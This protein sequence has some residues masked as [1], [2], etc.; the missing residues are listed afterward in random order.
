M[1]PLRWG[2]LSAGKISHDFAVATAELPKDEHQV[3]AVGAR[4]L[5]RATEFAKIHKI[6]K[7]Y[8]SYEQLVKDSEIDVVYVGSIHPQ[9]LELVKLSLDHG[10]HVLCEKPL[11]MNVKETKEMLE[12]AQS[13]QLFLMEAIWSRFFPL[14]VELRKRLESNSLGDVLQVMVTFGLSL[15][16]R[17]LDMAWPWNKELGGGTTLGIGIYC[18]QFA[19]MVFGEKP[20]KVIAGGHLNAGGV[21]QS[22]T[23]TLIFSNGR[24]ATLVTHYKV[25]LPNEAYIFGTKGTLKVR[26]PFW[27]PTELEEVGGK[28]ISFPLPTEKLK[29][30]FANSVGLHYQCHEVRNCISNGKTESSIVSHHHTLLI[31]EIMESIRTQVGVVYP[32]DKH[33]VNQGHVVD[34]NTNWGGSSKSSR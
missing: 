17:G 30:N 19:E 14:Y 33:T 32:Q 21:D 22:T 23:A 25:D 16:E 20:L 26:S 3:V 10:K 9:H 28:V 5:I 24:T 13:K 12:Y 4:D 2:I 7:A 31:A 8:G 15:T 29:C 27:C 34:Q 18:V 1:A 6:P 11:G